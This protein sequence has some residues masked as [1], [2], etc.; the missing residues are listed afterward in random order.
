MNK[1]VSLKKL[2]AASVGEYNRVIKYD[3]RVDN[4]Y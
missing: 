2:Y 4:V 3:Q 1:G